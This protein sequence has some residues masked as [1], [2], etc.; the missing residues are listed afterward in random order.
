MVTNNNLIGSVLCGFAESAVVTALLEAA[1]VG[2]RRGR[3]SGMEYLTIASPDER[4]E[5]LKTFWYGPSDFL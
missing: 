2:E 5:D 4:E 1:G 3:R